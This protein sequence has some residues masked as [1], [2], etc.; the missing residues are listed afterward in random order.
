MIA[1]IITQKLKKMV[2]DANAPTI[3]SKYEALTA[4][5]RYAALWVD[6][7]MLDAFKCVATSPGGSGLMQLHIVP[8]LSTLLDEKSPNSLK[9]AAILASPH[10]PWWQFENGK[11]LIQL[12]AKA[13]SAVPYT[14]DIGRSVVDA[15]LQIAH[16]K[17]PTI[18]DGMWS[19]LDK[20]PNLPPICS[21]RRLGSSQAVVEMVRGL[22]D[23]KTFTSYLLLVWSE[24]DFLELDGFK[25]MCSIL[26][27]FG[28]EELYHHRKDLL[29]RLGHVRTELKRGLRHFQHYKPGLTEDNF[30]DGQGQYMRLEEILLEANKKATAS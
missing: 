11:E 1:G 24:W 12:W 17:S 22:K 9:R 14:D 23:T 16:S 3:S 21:G 2:E 13:S 28:G 19:W 7:G 27:D 8:L 29:D 10:V 30:R 6:G 18:P 26:E 15:L 5:F 25:E 4:L 20:R